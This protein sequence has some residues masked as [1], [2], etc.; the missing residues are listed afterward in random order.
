[1]NPTLNASRCLYSR[2]GDLRPNTVRGR[3]GDVMLSPMRLRGPRKSSR[4]LAA[5]LAKLLMLVLTS[6][7][8]A[9]TDT[10]ENFT[11]IDHFGDSQELYYYRD[12]KAI[13]LIVQGNGCQIVRSSLSDY[14]ALRDDYR[15][16]GVKV[17]MLNSNLQDT[18]ASIRR[19]AQEW[20][21]DIPI[22]DDS[23]QLIGR[24]LGLTRTAEVL[25][26]DPR[27]WQLVYRGALNDRVDYERQKDSASENYVRDTLDTLLTGARPEFRKRNAPGCLINFPEATAASSISYAHDIVPILAQNCVHCHAEGGI[28]PWAMSDYRMVQGFAPMIREVIRTKRMPPWHADP[29]VGR[30]EHDGGLADGDADLLVRWIEAGAPRGKE[31]DP[32][33]KLQPRRAEWVLGEPDLIIEVPAFDVPASGVVDYQFPSVA[34]PLDEDVWVVAATI[35]PGDPQAVHHVLVGSADEPPEKDRQ[36]GVFQNYIMG[37]AP[38]NESQYMP[39]NTGVRVPV[40]GVYLF[41]MHYTP[42]GRAATD[43]TR[44]GLYFA[45]KGAPPDKFLRQQVIL[46]PLISIPPNEAAHEE[47]AYFEF[48]GDAVIYSLV[49]HA[50]YRGRSSEFELL[51]PD[52]ERELL[53]SVP[54]YDFN[55][56]RTYTLEQPRAVPEGT[57]II[58]RTVYDNSEK[59]RGNP[60]PER[61]VPWGLQ[62]FDEMLYGSVSFTWMDE[63]TR[64]PTHSNQL[65]D[66]AQWIGFMDG[67]MDGK[68]QRSEMPSWLS[69]RIGWKW[70]L[71]DRNFDGG[72]N[73]AEM[74][75]LFGGM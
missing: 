18:R 67:D 24:S 49:P 21:I 47:A 54:N 29:A 6:V 63:T 1:M 50:H 57:R 40:G 72:L 13:V 31:E 41:Q 42:Y 75:R 35:I 46:N 55:W 38:G 39:E 62:S 15:D 25:V 64:S 51:F 30:W 19:E 43:R 52:G 59:N 7:A 5:V 34:N 71:L 20:G 74:N 70:F 37:Y 28:A 60:D 3:M 73:L 66:T 58:H 56:Q 48:W 65:A 36:E 17:F 22:L 27:D 4:F 45:E 61:T 23:A 68:V 9:D 33:L 11:L 26:I 12:A 14:E 44:V 10:I 8:V 69:E 16:R 32:L 53:L 2:A